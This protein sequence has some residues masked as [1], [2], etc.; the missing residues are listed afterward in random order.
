MS[1][2]IFLPSDAEREK[3]QVNVGWTLLLATSSIEMKPIGP[4][5]N[6]MMKMTHPGYFVP[7]PLGLWRER[8]QFR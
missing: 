3:K 4:I 5:D 2:S 7:V 1:G 8:R 6:V